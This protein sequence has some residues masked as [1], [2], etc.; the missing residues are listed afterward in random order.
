M[1]CARTAGEL[2]PTVSPPWRDPIHQGQTHRSAF[3]SEAAVGS[4]NALQLGRQRLRPGAVKCRMVAVEKYLANPFQMSA[5]SGVPDV[6]PSASKARLG[7]R[8]AEQQPT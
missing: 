5:H 1:T 7:E 4:L 2:G 8:N 6:E 3:K